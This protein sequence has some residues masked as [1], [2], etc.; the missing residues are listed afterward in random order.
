[1]K[2]SAIGGGGE[3]VA[4]SSRRSDDAM[5]SKSLDLLGQQLPQR[6]VAVAQDAR[7]STAAAPHGTVG[8]EGEAMAG[9]S[10]HCDDTLVNQSLDLLRLLLVL[11]VAVA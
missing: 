2:D 6:L 10:R 7:D 3:A 1:M 5:A 9:C 4:A 8:G 11:L